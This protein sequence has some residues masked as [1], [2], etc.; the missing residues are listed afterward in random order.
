NDLVQI[1]EV[2]GAAAGEKWVAVDERGPGTDQH[3]RAVRRVHL[4][5]TPR[6]VVGSDRQG[7]VRCELGRVDEYGDPSGVR[8]F[9]DLVDRRDPSGDVGGARDGEQL[10]RRPRIEGIHDV[11]DG[12][13]A[14]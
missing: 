9:D 1:D 3:A 5:T 6:H 13:R 12:E 4:V 8:G 10:R 7:S 2:D 11:V 14:A